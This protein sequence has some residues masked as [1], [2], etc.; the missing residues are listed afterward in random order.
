[1]ITRHNIVKKE[2]FCI[3][4]KQKNTIELYSDE[5]EIEC[6]LDGG[7]YYMECEKE[8][9][10]EK[11]DTVRPDISLYEINSCGVP[12]LKY[13]FEIHDTNPVNEDKERKINIL[14]TKYETL[15]VFEINVD[16]YIRGQNGTTFRINIE[17][18]I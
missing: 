14:K 3:L 4:E 9:N 11:Y 18:E 7:T 8:I 1:M 16:N 12:E 10:C 15:R 2:L 6:E 13:I 17:R 5:G